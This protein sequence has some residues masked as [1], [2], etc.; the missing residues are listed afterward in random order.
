MLIWLSC[1]AAAV[2]I[3]V[4][5]AVVSARARAEAAERERKTA[6]ASKRSAF[7]DYALSSS[8]PDKHSQFLL[9]IQARDLLSK[10]PNDPKL[11][12]AVQL[13]EDGK[14]DEAGKLLEPYVFDE[15]KL[16]SGSPS[17]ASSS[18]VQSSRRY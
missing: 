9:E 6:A 4:V 14:T 7:L 8:F 18:P 1:G 12:K 3:V 13:L 15:K 2:V 16:S 10:H 5:A 17:N 11:A